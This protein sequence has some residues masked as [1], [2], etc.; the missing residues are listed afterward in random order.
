MGHI[1][2]SHPA[3]QHKCCSNFAPGKF[4][5]GLRRYGPIGTLSLISDFV[6]SLKAR[7]SA[8]FLRAG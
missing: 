3:G 7:I 5:G 2:V 6:G 8:P 1:L 4:V